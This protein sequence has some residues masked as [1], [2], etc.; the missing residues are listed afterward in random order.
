[1][2]VRSRTNASDEVEDDDEAQ[3]TKPWKTTVLVRRRTDAVRGTTARSCGGRKQRRTR[4]PVDRSGSVGDTRLDGKTPQQ[5]VPG[6]RVVTT[7]VGDLPS[8]MRRFRSFGR[9]RAHPN[10]PTTHVVVSF[11]GGK[12]RQDGSSAHRWKRVSVRPSLG[13]D[14]VFG[15]RPRP[16]F[17]R[18]YTIAASVLAREETK[19]TQR[20]AASHVDVSHVTRGGAAEPKSPTARSLSGEMSHR[21]KRTGSPFPTNVGSLVPHPLRLRS[22]LPPGGAIL[23]ARPRS[24]PS[25][26]LRPSIHLS[27]PFY[28]M[29]Q[30]MDSFPFPFGDS[31]GRLSFSNPTDPGSLGG[32]T[33]VGTWLSSWKCLPRASGPKVQDHRVVLRQRAHRL[34][35]HAIVR[36]EAARLGGRPPTHPRVQ[37]DVGGR[38]ATWTP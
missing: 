37:V 29:S 7:D 38:D 30:R 25:D 15:T 14:L 3:R 17:A 26:V 35:T 31:P 27:F 10:R 20:R 11:V 18:L 2:V 33:S 34:A 6:K 13:V 8:L 21:P 22:S 16:T 12:V 28:R 9:E 19:Q 1:M 5:M 23:L 32:V 36:Q 24:V 4:S